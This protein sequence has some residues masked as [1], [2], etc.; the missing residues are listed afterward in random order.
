MAVLT[1]GSIA[2]QGAATSARAQLATP[3]T[4]TAIHARSRTDLITPKWGNRFRFVR[5]Q[6]HFKRT[7]HAA[8]S[9]LRREQGEEGVGDPRGGGDDFCRAGRAAGEV[10]RSGA[11]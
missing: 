3:S 9:G 8:R 7:K 10:A 1:D 5:F 11:G 4:G 6:P 2:K